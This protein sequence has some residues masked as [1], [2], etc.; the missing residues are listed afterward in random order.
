[1]PS[2]VGGGA[3]G[4]SA[5]PTPGGAAS[6]P[7]HNLSE[8]AGPTHGPASVGRRLNLLRGRLPR[9]PGGFGSGSELACA[10]QV[11]RPVAVEVSERPKSVG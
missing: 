3:G 8:G 9:C 2:R 1:M 4:R 11:L 6:P 7:P 5:A 10:S